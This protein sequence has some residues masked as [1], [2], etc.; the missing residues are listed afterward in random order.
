M[1]NHCET[2][3]HSTKLK[4]WFNLLILWKFVIISINLLTFSFNRSNI[5]KFW[6]QPEKIKKLTNIVKD[7]LKKIEQ[8]FNLILLSNLTTKL[9]I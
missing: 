7:R 2:I 3:N 8:I 5:I 9:K 4:M 6:K 1:K